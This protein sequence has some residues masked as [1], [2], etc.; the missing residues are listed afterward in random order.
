MIWIRTLKEMPTASSMIWT[1]LTES[2][3]Y[4]YDVNCNIMSDSVSVS[5]FDGTS[6]YV[7]YLKPKPS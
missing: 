2:I 1:W 7:G 5:L 4:N 6:T 3:S